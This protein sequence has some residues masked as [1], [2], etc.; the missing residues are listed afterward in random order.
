MKDIFIQRYKDKVMDYFN[1]T[2]DSD[3]RMIRRGVFEEYAK[4]LQ[5]VFGMTEKEVSDMYHTL[6]AE[7]YFK[8]EE[9]A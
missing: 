5:E 3:G 1:W 2:Y 6:Y 4:I 8:K 9:T 7:K